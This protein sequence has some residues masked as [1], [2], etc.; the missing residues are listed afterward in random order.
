MGS[1]R[2]VALDLLTLGFSVEL[3]PCLCETDEVSTTQPIPS[4]H[5][6]YSTLTWRLTQNYTKTCAKGRAP[7]TA[8]TECA[9]QAKTE[10][11]R[12]V[13]I[14]VGFFTLMKAN[15]LVDFLIIF[16]LA[17][18]Q[19]NCSASS[20]SCHQKLKKKKTKEGVHIVLAY[21]HLSQAL[22]TGN[23]I[24]RLN[25]PFIYAFFSLTLLTFHPSWFADL[26]H[27]Y[28]SFWET[29]FD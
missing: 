19:V 8:L 4:K 10:P 20:S 7:Q 29:G 17:P 23:F 22:N 28:I 12:S 15:Q 2:G 25:I 26:S 18:E 13:E 1:W 27:R 6:R 3:W 24:C 11:D 14:I 21:C 5:L 9:H 16:Y